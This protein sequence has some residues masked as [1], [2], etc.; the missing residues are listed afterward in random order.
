MNRAI[1]KLQSGKY[2]AAKTDYKE[3]EKILP[4]PSYAVYYG[5]G[6]IASKTNDRSGAIC[7]FKKYLKY[8]PENSDEAKQVRDR[9]Q[10][11]ERGA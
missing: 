8:A 3:L 1:A 11:L 10:K 9:L 2:D 5:L 4:T 6:E 7:S